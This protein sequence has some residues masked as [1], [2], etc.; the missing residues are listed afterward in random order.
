M[1]DNRVSSSEVWR[2]FDAA[3]TYVAEME[4]PGLTTWQALVEALQDWAPDGVGF[5]GGSDLDPFR[6]AL[7]YLCEVTPEL[8]APGGVSLESILESVMLGWT[9]AASERLNDGFPF[10]G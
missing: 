7:A 4:R 3:V 6:T 5:V 8:G 10:V 9:E 1:N 2:E